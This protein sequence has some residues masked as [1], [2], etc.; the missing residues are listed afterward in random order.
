MTQ[1]ESHLCVF[2]VFRHAVFLTLDKMR[3]ALIRFLSALDVDAAWCALF[4][5]LYCFCHSFSEFI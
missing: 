2:F 1:E 5:R 3:H 4:H